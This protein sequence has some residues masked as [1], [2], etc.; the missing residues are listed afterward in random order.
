MMYTLRW[1][2][3][4]TLAKK[5][6]IGSANI[7]KEILSW[8]RSQCLSFLALIWL[9]KGHTFH[10][11]TDRFVHEHCPISTQ[12]LSRIF[13]K[14]KSRMLRITHLLRILIS[15]SLPL[16]LPFCITRYHPLL[17]SFRFLCWIHVSFIVPTNSPFKALLFFK[18]TNFS[19][20]FF[21]SSFSLLLYSFLICPCSFH[22][23]FFRSPI[24][25]FIEFTQPLFHTF[26][27]VIPTL[28]SLLVYI[29]LSY[30]I[31][32]LH[33]YCSALSQSAFLYPFSFTYLSFVSLCADNSPCIS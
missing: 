19:Y 18:L 13:S 12:C 31:S 4:T 27:A 23:S 33:L 21:F 7:I 9:L 11:C 28:L 16:L 2:D 1:E 24:I 29:Y 17:T 32:I 14:P 30:H 5:S 6:S 15:L 26:L 3:G 10:H 8:T 22:S 20:F 25:V